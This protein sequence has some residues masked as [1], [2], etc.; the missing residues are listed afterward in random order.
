[1]AIL[2]SDTCEEVGVRRVGVGLALYDVG[3]GVFHK[4]LLIDVAVRAVYVHAEELTHVAQVVC[5]AS[6]LLGSNA[7]TGEAI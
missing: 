6:K 3:S 1:M 2:A 7:R 5:G 4:H